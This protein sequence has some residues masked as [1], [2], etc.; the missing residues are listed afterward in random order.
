MMIMSKHDLEHL[1]WS[2]CSSSC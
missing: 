2:L 1:I